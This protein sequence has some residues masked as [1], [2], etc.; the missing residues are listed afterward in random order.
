MGDTGIMSELSEIEELGL[1]VFS[2]F[3]F[4]L[5]AS[6]TFFARPRFFSHLGVSMDKARRL[7]LVPVIRLASWFICHHEDFPVPSF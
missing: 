7:D 4:F 1:G 6:T 3:R 2:G 5:M